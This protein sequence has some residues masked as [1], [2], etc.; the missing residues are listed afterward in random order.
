KLHQAIKDLVHHRM[1]IN[2]GSVGWIEGRRVPSE[3]AP[4]DAAKA[5]GGVFRRISSCHRCCK[6]E[7]GTESQER[8]EV[9][10]QRGQTSGR[11]DTPL[12][13]KFRCARRGAR[14]HGVYSSPLETSCT[15]KDLFSYTDLSAR[16]PRLWLSPL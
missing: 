9:P 10:G 7:E 5:C 1:R 12:L 4:I 16:P 3:G 14:C 11:A 2:I 8:S 6:G 15:S 13:P